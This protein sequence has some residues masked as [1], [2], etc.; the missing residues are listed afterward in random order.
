M[1]NKI[2]YFLLDIESNCYFHPNSKVLGIIDGDDETMW[3]LD[4]VYNLIKESHGL[5]NVEKES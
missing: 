4:C 5:W 3:C 1:N 2:R